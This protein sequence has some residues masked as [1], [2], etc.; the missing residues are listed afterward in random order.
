MDYK[1]QRTRIDKLSREKMLEELENAAKSF[2]YIEF[3]WR[4]FNKVANISANPVK[5]EFGS[6]CN[7]LS[8]LREHLKEKNLNLSPRKIPY[9]QIH[10]DKDMFNEMERIWKNLWHRPSRTEWEQSNYKIAYG[11]YKSRFNGWQ[12]ACLKFIEYKMGKNIIADAEKIIPTDK[13][14]TTLKNK[15]EDIRTIP[16]RMK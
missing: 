3:G 10:S 14:Y 2:N 12:N 5:K 16:L 9:N 1:F 8:A 7:A 13:I 4:D 15:S 11:T 6:W